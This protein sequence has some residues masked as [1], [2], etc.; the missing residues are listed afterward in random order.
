MR[1]P[2]PHPKSLSHKQER[3]RKAVESPSPRRFAYGEGFRVRAEQ[4]QNSILFIAINGKK[5]RYTDTRAEKNEAITIQIVV[6]I[7]GGIG[8]RRSPL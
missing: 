5:A 6:E 4:L 8:A 3:G 1:P 2:F 7:K